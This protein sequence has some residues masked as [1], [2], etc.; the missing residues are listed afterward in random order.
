MSTQ[1]RLVPGT[2]RLREDLPALRKDG[3]RSRDWRYQPIK[4]GTLFFY[5]EPGALWPAGEHSHDS[6]PI[7]ESI[8]TRYLEELLV[9]V[10]ETPSHWVRR[11]H[12]SSFACDILDGLLTLGKITM[13]DIQ[14]AA[15]LILD[16]ANG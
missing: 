4:A 9:R 8:A 15:R 5:S 3:R 12:S 14:Q 11:E 1:T 10:D 7:D 2:Y 13:P 6:V 16:E